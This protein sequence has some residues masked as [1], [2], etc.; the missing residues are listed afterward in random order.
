MHIQ[1]NHCGPRQ[2]VRLGT[3]PSE[4]VSCGE[5]QDQLT[6][7]SSKKSIPLETWGIE[8]SPWA[9]KH[10]GGPILVDEKI[11]YLILVPNQ[12]TTI[13]TFEP[14]GSISYTPQ[15]GAISA[16]GQVL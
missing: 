9:G 7:R 12:S 3:R 11:D 13:V 8:A 5:G 16:A 14:I 6:H 2:L 4:A 15:K 10:W 1:S